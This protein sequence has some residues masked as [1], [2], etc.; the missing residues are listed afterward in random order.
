MAT[1][2]LQTSSAI[3]PTTKLLRR[4]APVRQVPSTV[5]PTVIGLGRPA[6]AGILAAGP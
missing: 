4:P 6:R 5:G 3:V 1:A 2:V